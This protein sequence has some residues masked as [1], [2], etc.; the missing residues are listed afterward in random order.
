MD[1]A[2]LNRLIANIVRTGKILEVQA[3]L[4]RV[5]FSPELQT[6][7]LQYF[8]PFAGG[9]SVHRMPSKGE[10][11][12]VLAPSGD[13]EAAMVLCGIA[14]TDHPSPS[15][16][17]DETV[18]QFPDGAS[19]KYNHKASHLEIAGI[20]TAVVNAGQSSEINC[21][22]NTINGATTINGL[23]TCTQ[24]MNISGGGAATAVFT[25]N[26]EHNGNYD[27]TG[28]ISSNGVVL[29]THT[30]G[31]VMAGGANTGKPS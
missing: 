25:G 13:L 14:S 28:R 1:T 7:W 2:E 5:E 31:G 8:V 17:A 19:V 12:V 26:V 9:V 29:H 27:N 24:G 6:D 21:P 30:H 15:S 3:G 4:V 11:C 22:Q 23:L 18:V 16:S 20:N 10:S